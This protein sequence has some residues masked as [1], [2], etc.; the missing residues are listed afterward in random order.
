MRVSV[1]RVVCGVDSIRKLSSPV[2]ALF[3][4]LKSL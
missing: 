1:S 4:G 2:P 3:V